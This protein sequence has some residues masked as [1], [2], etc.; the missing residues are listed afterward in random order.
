MGERDVFPHVGRQTKIRLQGARE[1]VYPVITG[2]FG[3]VDF[4]HSVMGEFG[5][6]ASQSEIE[7]LVS[8]KFPGVL[9]FILDE[10]GAISSISIFSGSR[11]QR[12]A[13]S[14]AKEIC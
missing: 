3:G 11:G 12:K 6:K 10:L 13:L 14:P 4:L 5:D 7:E 2:T 1:E 8:P 9:P